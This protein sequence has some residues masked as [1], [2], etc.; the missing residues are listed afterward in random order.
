[1]S[2]RILCADCGSK[3][4]RHPQD[5]ADGWQY[6]VVHLTVKKPDEHGVTIITDDSVKRSELPSILCDTCGA[7]IAD[8][9]VALAVTM[10]REGEIGMWEGGYGVV[11]PEAAARM[12]KVLSK[13][14]T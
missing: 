3:W 13:G 12:E 6:R 7:V 1:M 9:S 10:W 2:R 4:K 8:G 11:I 5:V 14:E